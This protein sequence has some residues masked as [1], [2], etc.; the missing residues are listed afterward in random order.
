[1]DDSLIIQLFWDRSE[2]AIHETSAKYG[3]YCRSIAWNILLNNEDTEECVNDTYMNLWNSI[4]PQKPNSL[5]AY[6]AKI[7]RN[8]SLNKYKYKNALKRKSTEMDL[9][10][11]ELEGC[12]PSIGGTEADYE[13]KILTES[14]ST[15]IR[16]LPKNSQVAFIRRYWYSDSIQAIAERLNITESTVR[17]MLFR[18]RGKLKKY[19]AREGIAL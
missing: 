11:D 16:T 2:S 19:L 9:I 1:M 18:S 3:N 7:T 17:S 4:P 8:L 10:F 14:L 13:M 6:A 12:I 5:S 15:F